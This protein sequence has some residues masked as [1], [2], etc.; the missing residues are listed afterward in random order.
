MAETRQLA[1]DFDED[2]YETFDTLPMSESRDKTKTSNKP[3]PVE[4]IE[5]S[6]PSTE[7]TVSSDASTPETDSGR[8]ISTEG[9]SQTAPDAS[10]RERTFSTASTQEMSPGDVEIDDTTIEEAQAEP[11]VEL[12]PVERLRRCL[13]RAYTYIRVSWREL[14]QSPF[15]MYCG[16]FALV[17][18][19]IGI[20]FL[21]KVINLYW[22]K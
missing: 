9:T 12:T 11:V 20:I 14:K 13:I 10:Q 2:Q 4:N 3:A 7:F 19:V 17:A 5:M 8:S 18:I 6:S 16:S 21:M 1:D 15:A 22:K